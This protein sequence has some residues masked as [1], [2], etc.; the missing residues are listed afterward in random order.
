MLRGYPL[1]AGQVAYEKHFTLG[2]YRFLFLLK[3]HN[4][5][6]AAKDLLAYRVLL[7]GY[8]L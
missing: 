6:S 3:K 2:V 5:K 4:D 8:Y 7:I 1:S